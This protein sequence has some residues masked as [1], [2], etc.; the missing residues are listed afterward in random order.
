M[1]VTYL[2]RKVIIFWYI[3]EIKKHSL[4]LQ[5][6][7]VIYPYETWYIYNN[8]IISITYLSTYLDQSK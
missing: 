7:L 3:D 1:K 4:N 8:I 2:K 6:F 5:F